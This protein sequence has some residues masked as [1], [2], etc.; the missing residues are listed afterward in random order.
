MALNSKS[1]QDR[2]LRP[3]Q[4]DGSYKHPDGATDYDIVMSEKLTN[5]EGSELIQLPQS[6]RSLK[7]TLL[8]LALLMLS[9][10]PRNYW[11]IHLSMQKERCAKDPK[12]I[13]LPVIGKVDAGLDVPEI[14]AIEHLLCLL[15]PDRCNKYP[16]WN[17][18]CYSLLDCRNGCN[19]E[20]LRRVRSLNLVSLNFVR[21]FVR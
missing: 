1:G 17:E 6:L 5:V 12:Y 7:V 14:D 2:P 9:G 15:H 16:F 11:T 10:L 18:V 13:D 19:D 4:F 3:I 8:M 21:I 20:Q